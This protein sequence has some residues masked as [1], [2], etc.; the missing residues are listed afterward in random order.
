MPDDPRIPVEL[1][2]PDR[3]KAEEPDKG[4]A[5]CLSGGGYRAMLFHVGALWR[6]QEL[7][8]LNC[9]ASAPRAA[10]LGPLLRVSSVSGGSITSAQL[11]LTWRD[12]KTAD[13]SAAVRRAAFEE[14]V[15][16]KIREFSEVNI[17][18]FNV[19]GVLNIIAA[20]LL[21]G[22]VNDYVAKQYAK[23]L[24]RDKTLA[25]L[26]DEPRFVINATNLQSGAL[27]RFTKKYIWDWRVGKIPNSSLV[28]VARA[29]AASSAFPPPLSPATFKF[30]DTD[31]QPGTGSGLQWPPYTTHVVLSDG[32]VYDNLGLETAWKNCR[33]VLVSNAGKPFQFEEK[34]SVNW[35]SQGR[36][37]IDVIDNQ[38]RTLRVRTLIDSYQTTTCGPPLRSGCYWGIGSDASHFPRPSP[39][40][41]PVDKTQKLAAVTTD[42]AKKNKATQE[43]LINWGYAICDTAMRS[44]V[45]PA[46]PAPG[47]FP[48]PA[49][50]VG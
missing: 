30:K 20:I 3:A 9:T 13:A 43:R 11:A 34:I 17:A 29:V 45:D 8:Y 15:V 4:I 33:T 1:I 26:P 10:D 27:W 24:F 19:S 12:C 21:P 28:S 31:Y 49:Q 22:S 38:V 47:N 2:A 7:G 46:L 42:L 40:P 50:G 23:H 41:C 44:W 6:L 18:G 5:I 32:G 48:Y 39:L 36:R 25:D 37:V 35:A 14:H 16:K